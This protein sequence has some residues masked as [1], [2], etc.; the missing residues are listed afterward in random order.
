M[1]QSAGGRNPPSLQ[2]ILVLEPEHGTRDHV[3]VLLNRVNSAGELL[4][5][6][7]C[8]LSV[9]QREQ[10]TAR[11]AIHCADVRIEVAAWLHQFEDERDHHGYSKVQKPPA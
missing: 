4:R 8:G 5:L 2:R 6:L 3:G 9:S 7:A 1:R 10:P 11:R